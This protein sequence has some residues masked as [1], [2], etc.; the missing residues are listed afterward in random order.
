MEFNFWRLVFFFQGG[1]FWLQGSESFRN[2]GSCHQVAV[3]FLAFV[4]SQKENP[5]QVGA[6]Q[7]STESQRLLNKTIQL[8]TGDHNTQW[9]MNHWPKFNTANQWPQQIKN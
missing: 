4:N 7:P 5:K 3:E 8:I 2:S 6:W 1:C 9:L